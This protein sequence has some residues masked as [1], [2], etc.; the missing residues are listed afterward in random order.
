MTGLVDIEFNTGG[1]TGR[2]KS[3]ITMIEFTLQIVDETQNYKEIDLYD[4]VVK[5]PKGRTIIN[6][7]IK[8]LTT[9]SQEEIDNGVRM[10]EFYRKLYEYYQKYDLKEIYTW[11][12]CDQDVVHWNFG[13]YDIEALTGLKREQVCIKFTDL[14]TVIKDKYDGR[15]PLSLI[16]MAVL[17]EYKP[18]MQHRAYADVETMRNILIELKHTDDADMRSRFSAYDVYADL[19]DMYSKMRKVISIAKEYDI[20]VD[21][22]LSTA[23][24]GHEFPVFDEAYNDTYNKRTFGWL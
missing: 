4:V 10:D 1:P 7:K 19:K 24:N 12:N 16:N 6:E 11:G 18:V 22:M 3:D 2:V 21:E 13:R 8:E 20:D 15:H 23:K 9:I 14:S 5:P 17:C